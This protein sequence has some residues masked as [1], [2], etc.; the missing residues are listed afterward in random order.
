MFYNNNIY[1][2]ANQ[3]NIYLSESN[4]KKS[5]DEEN[6][7]VLDPTMEMKI[8]NELREK[9]TPKKL[10]NLFLADAYNMAH[11]A[12]GENKAKRLALCNRWLEFA[13]NEEYEKYKL[14]KTSSCHVRL[15]PICQWRRSLNTFRHLVKIYQDKRLRNCKHIFLTL[16]QR[17][18]SGDDLRTE[19][20]KI[21]KSFTNFIRKTEIKNI[22]QGYIR[23]IEI[24]KNKKNGTYHPHI[25]AILSVNLTYG[26]KKYITQKR[27][28]E[29]WQESLNIDYK[30]VIHVKMIKKMDFKSLVEIA[31]YSVK[32]FDYIS[33]KN[34][35]ETI[36]ELEILDPALDRKRFISMGGLVK[37]IKREIGLTDI[38]NDEEIDIEEDIS[39]WEKVLYEWHYGKQEYFRRHDV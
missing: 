31:K 39:N 17:N 2:N 35:H 26:S 18:I 22:L 16:T 6:K 15:C 4:N 11:M 19:I 8:S 9:Y 38:E 32:P 21:S 33:L 30:P 29:M 36:K 10:D 28:S 14:V 23:S 3:I 37:D 24:T 27:F 7:N 1:L 13:V 12:N 20:E 34:I 25:H 5:Q